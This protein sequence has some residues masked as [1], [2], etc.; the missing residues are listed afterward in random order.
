[1]PNGKDTRQ[2]I[3]LAKTVRLRGTSG[4]RRS[5][6]Y[7]RLLLLPL[8]PK[9]GEYLIFGRALRCYEHYIKNAYLC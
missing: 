6:C 7:V 4:L 3:S 2:I 1:M 9:V 5:E 8:W